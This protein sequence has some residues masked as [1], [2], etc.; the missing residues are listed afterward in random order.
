MLSLLTATGTI[1]VNRRTTTRT[2]WA[3]AGVDCDEIIGGLTVLGIQPLGWT[4]PSAAPCT[5]PP[6][7][8]QA[9]RWP[10][11][12]SGDAWVFVTENPSI[13][14][15]AADLVARDAER[16][17]VVRLI[18]TMGNPSGLEISAITALA[19]AGW[20]LAIRAD[21]DATGI[22]NVTALLAAAPTARPWRMTTRDYLDSAPAAPAKEPVPAT[23][24]DPDLAPTINATS[25]TA[26]EEALLP[27]ILWSRFS[28]HCLKICTP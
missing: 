28:R 14:A 20:N 6:R 19:D 16:D 2:A 10:T 3:Q 21:F 17:A 5:L 24:W 7:Q 23:P 25:Q 18:C 26:F 22:R 13:I 27:N 4:L 1:T 8:L 11:A 15:A 12:P 9:A